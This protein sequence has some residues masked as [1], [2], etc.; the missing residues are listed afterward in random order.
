MSINRV[1]LSKF[2]IVFGYLMAVVYIGLGCSFFFPKVFPA[3]PRNL[4][5]VFALFFISYG[6]FRLVKMRPKKNEINE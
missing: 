2:M 6:L 3:I 1:W 4:K 5:F